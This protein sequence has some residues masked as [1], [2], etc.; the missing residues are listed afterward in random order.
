MKIQK[1]ITPIKYPSF[2]PDAQAFI[3][4]A[5]ITN[6]IQKNAI[7][8]L[9]LGLKSDSL[10]TKM[11][12][13]YPFVGG[14]ATSH[15]YNLKNTAQYQISFSGSWTH[16]ATGAKPNGVNAFANTNL[17]YSSVIGLNPTHYSLYSRTQIVES[18]FDMGCYAGGQENWMSVLY[19]PDVF[20]YYP[21][22]SGI[23]PGG[24]TSSQGLFVGT[25][26]SPTIKVFRNGNSVASTGSTTYNA[27]NLNVY[28]GATNTSGG[29]ALFSSKEL[30]FCSIGDGLTDTDV[31]NLYNLVQTYNTTLSRQV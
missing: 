21:N 18:S 31:T 16:S 7:N 2:D 6:Q 13:I 10:W 19:A 20:Y 14:N 12:A 11:D 27:T 25:F 17:N 30:A 4:A 3:I 1:A 9:V 15:S 28:L 29:A 22:T 8:T 24:Q 5:S 26:T 23:G